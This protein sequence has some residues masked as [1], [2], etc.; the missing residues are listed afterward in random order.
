M[1]RD[2]LESLDIKNIIYNSESSQKIEPSSNLQQESENIESK[3]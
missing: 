2:R 1:N 3:E